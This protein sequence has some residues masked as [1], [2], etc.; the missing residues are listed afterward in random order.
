MFKNQNFGGKR[1][2]SF[3]IRIIKCDNNRNYVIQ[4]PFKYKNI[5]PNADYYAEY[6]QLKLCD[7]KMWNQLL[8]IYNKKYL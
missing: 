6:N 4:F 5:E 3:P 1:K 8:E 7:D 2:Y